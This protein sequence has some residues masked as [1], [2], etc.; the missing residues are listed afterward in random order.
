MTPIAAYTTVTGT[1]TAGHAGN[2]IAGATAHAAGINTT[3]IG[4]HTD[5]SRDDTVTDTN[6][7]TPW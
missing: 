3:P 6:N 5:D 4:R 2:S 1:S 7:A